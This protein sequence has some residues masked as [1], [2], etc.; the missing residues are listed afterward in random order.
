MRAV[1]DT[2]G[3]LRMAAG[4]SRSQLA[5]L[6]RARRYDLLMSLSTLTELRTVLARPALQAYVPPAIGDQFLGLV[7]T[8]A[9]FVQPNL[10][11]PT[12]R[13]PQDSALIATAVGGRAAYLV[14]A[15]PDILDD[16]SLGAALAE[17]GVRVTTA[18]GFLSILSGD[19][20]KS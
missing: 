12:C 20:I 16:L 15:D 18:A 10:A 6:W 8:R 14:S 19:Q 3:L 5:Q 1:I 4:G 9:V 13:D 2:N 7:E 17:R 11:A